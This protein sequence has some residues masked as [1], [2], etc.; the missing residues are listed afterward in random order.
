MFIVSWPYSMQGTGGER[1]VRHAGVHPV[2]GDTPTPECRLT[3]EFSVPVVTNS[4]R[5]T[6]ALGRETRTLNMDRTAFLNLITVDCG[7][8]LFTDRDEVLQ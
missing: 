2:G 8:L 1:G 5:S 6:D 4:A 7:E 3:A